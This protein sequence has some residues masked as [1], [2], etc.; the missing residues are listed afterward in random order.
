L[1][2]VVASIQA[3]TQSTKRVETLVNEINVGSHEQARGIEQVAKAVAQMERV[4]QK[5]AASAEESASAG[6]EL[7]AQS[8]ALRAVVETLM[9]TVEGAVDAGSDRRVSS[10]SSRLTTQTKSS[11]RLRTVAVETPLFTRSSPP[12]PVPAGNRS[13][14]SAIP[15][16]EDFV[17]F[18]TNG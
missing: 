1:N 12:F 5:T 16:E 9:M 17:P 15:F 8:S 6:E 10:H 7:S 14:T 4:T 18:S 2:E 11:P 13:D 3:I